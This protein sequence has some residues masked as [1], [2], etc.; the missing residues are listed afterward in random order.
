MAGNDVDFREPHVEKPVFGVNLWHRKMLTGIL[1][2]CVIFFQTAAD[3]LDHIPE[4]SMCVST[5]QHNRIW[6]NSLS[7][8]DSDSP[9]ESGYSFSERRNNREASPYASWSCKETT[10]I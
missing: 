8:W 2:E 6:W 10:L 3:W 9:R 5:I 4:S 1:Y 7:N